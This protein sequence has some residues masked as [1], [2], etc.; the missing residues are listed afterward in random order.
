[1]QVITHKMYQSLHMYFTGQIDLQLIQEK[2]RIKC[3][4]IYLQLISKQD[5][6]CKYKINFCDMIRKYYHKNALHIFVMY[7]QCETENG[8]GQQVEDLMCSQSI[9]V[10]KNTDKC[11]HLTCAQ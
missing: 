5:Q 4:T 8:Q 2:N 1:M 3:T 7:L 11:S 10:H 9:S 6:N